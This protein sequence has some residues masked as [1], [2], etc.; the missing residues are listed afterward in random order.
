[1]KIVDFSIIVACMACMT[2]MGCQVGYP[3]AVSDP[4]TL[5][6]QRMQQENIQSMIQQQYLWMHP[7]P[8]PE[9][10]ARKQRAVA[11]IAH[12]D[13]INKIINDPDCNQDC[14]DFLQYEASLIREAQA[15][16]NMSEH[17]TR[18]ISPEKIQQDLIEWKRMFQSSIPQ[19]DQEV[20]Y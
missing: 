9:T 12:L 19:K 8:D 14:K 6:H 10:E 2:C 11:D 13:E 20:P 4:E 1:M 17:C 18:L 16:D 7:A 5:A 3:P 15:C